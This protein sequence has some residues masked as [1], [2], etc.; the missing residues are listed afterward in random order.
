MI[1][2]FSLSNFRSIRKT[3]TLSMVATRL[4]EHP[5]NCFAA[6]DKP[7]LR[8]LKSAQIYGANA[9]GKTNVVRGL[10]ALGNLVRNSTDRKVNDPLEQHQPFR[11]DADSPGKPTRFEIEFIGEDGL[12][13]RY[14]VETTSNRIEYEALYVYP[15]GQAAT[16]FE[17]RAGK[18]IRFG[19]YLKGPKKDI[20]RQL[21][22]NVLFLSKA[23][24]NKNEQLRVV[25]EYVSRLALWNCSHVDPLFSR[26]A[27]PMAA[28]AVLEKEEF[29]G[30]MQRLLKYADTGIDSFEVKAVAAEMWDRCYARA[31]GGSVE[32]AGDVNEIF[33]R[34]VRMHHPFYKD[35]ERG[36]AATFDVEDESAGTIQFFGLGA[37]ALKSLRLGWPMVVD[38]LDRS[39]HPALSAYLVRLF[40]SA[41]TNPKTAQLIFT[42]HDVSLLDPDLFRRD[43]T[44]FTEKSKQGE[45]ELYSLAE[46]KIR[47]PKPPFSL[48][49]WYLSGKFGAVPLLRDVALPWM[50]D[51][52][53]TESA[54]EGK[55]G[56]DG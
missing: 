21:L 6:P 20:E 26:M 44:Y 4:K 7:K 36:G 1:I 31:M 11:L 24:N 2:E 30:P 49:K 5:G 14:E 54:N 43:Q 55:G 40:H 38:E 8:L 18:L 3:Q 39:L 51:Q 32:L 52:P 25:F 10:V 45:T 53:E 34:P 12:R 27:L 33:S 46:F 22:E 19:D 28:F 16:L 29:R 56:D 47:P 35:N 37:S 41:E 23:A 17:R 50:E 13:C 15:K 48:A 42:T 9:S